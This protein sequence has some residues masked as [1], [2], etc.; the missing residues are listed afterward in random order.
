MLIKFKAIKCLENSEAIRSNRGK[1][2]NTWLPS[3]DHPK[4]FRMSYNVKWASYIKQ[5]KSVSNK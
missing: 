5:N 1:V 4:H 3:T 2:E